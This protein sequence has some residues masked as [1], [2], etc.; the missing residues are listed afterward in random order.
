[1][2]TA[3]IFNAIEGWDFV[4]LCRLIRGGVDLNV[5]SESGTSALQLSAD[6]HQFIIFTLLV[7][8]G[9]DPSIKNQKDGTTPLQSIC[10]Y[11]EGMSRETSMM[12]DLLFS[13]K[14]DVNAQDYHG[15]TALH[16]ATGN[17]S[18][19]YVQKLLEHGADCR[20]VNEVHHAPLY[21]AIC[22][23]AEQTILQLL[24]AGSNINQ[25]D[26]C[27]E[28]MLHEFTRAQDT[29]A[30]VIL[31]KHGVDYKIQNSQDLTAYDLALLR[32]DA[33]TAQ[34]IF[35]TIRSLRA[36]KRKLIG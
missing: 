24:N 15:N 5:F 8:G 16:R 30:I 2:S 18:S 13:R 21:F 14:V 9:A 25:L 22:R 29:T 27:G 4:G 6:L 26:D 20:I 19:L 1:M 35:H 31:L 10:D 17:N 28:T 32:G 3:D 11:N 7:N 33:P 34:V 36:R 12:L 23:R